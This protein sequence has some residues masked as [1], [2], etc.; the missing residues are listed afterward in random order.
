MIVGMPYRYPMDEVGC[1][2]LIL[3]KKTI[4]FIYFS[5]RELAISPID[6]LLP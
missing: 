5:L 6:L 2:G 1:S 3:T 4:K